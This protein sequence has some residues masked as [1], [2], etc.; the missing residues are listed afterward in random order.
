MNASMHLAF[1][2]DLWW[3]IYGE[4]RVLLYCRK[5]ISATRM[6]RK[7]KTATKVETHYQESIDVLSRYWGSVPMK[8]R[9]A[10]P[11]MKTIRK[12]GS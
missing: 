2:Y 4:F 1:D 3:R 6:H 5:F 9:I 7:T 12:L 10:L 8:W 11:I